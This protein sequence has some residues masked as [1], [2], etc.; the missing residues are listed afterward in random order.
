MKKF[1]GKLIVA[2]ILLVV[3]VGGGVF[4]LGRGPQGSMS[5]DE[6]TGSTQARPGKTVRR[7][8]SR[9]VEAPVEKGNA[10]QGEIKAAAGASGTTEDPEGEEPS[11]EAEDLEE[12][13]VDE[14]DALTDK[15]Q[16]PAADKVTMEEV[17]RFREQFSKIPKARKEECIHRALNLVPDENVMLLA[18]ILFDKSQDREI[19]ELVYNDI[20]NRDEDVKKPILREVFKDKNHPCW[21][22]TAWIL[23]VTGELPNKKGEDDK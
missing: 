2:I 14:F 22:D 1:G 4:F 7:P 10:V 8:V 17:R 6:D 5:V 11:E 12:K 21:A 23:D 13:L 15:W 19:L 18:G 20:L 9:R 3:A 16:E